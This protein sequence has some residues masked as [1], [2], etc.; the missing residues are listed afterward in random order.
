MGLGIS[1]NS[2]REPVPVPMLR[3]W[4]MSAK[5]P[6]VATHNRRGKRKHVLFVP[7]EVFLYEEKP[8]RGPHLTFFTSLKVAAM[9]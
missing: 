1:K 3:A 4:K 2:E 6:A 8:S 9:V 7:F 5:T